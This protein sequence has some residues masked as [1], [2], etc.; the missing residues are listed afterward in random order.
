MG[1]S[2]NW[3]GAARLGAAV[4]LAAGSPAAGIAGSP[5]AGR[6]GKPLLEVRDLAIKFYTDD[7]VV[8]AV[9]G[10]SLSLGAGET[11]GLVGETGAGKTTT[12]L[13]IMGLVDSPPGRVE[14]GRILFEGVDLLSLREEQYRKYRGREISMIFQDPMTALNP[15][16]TVLDQI[17]E[18]I[19]NH[20]SLKPREAA[21][22]AVEML[23]LVRIPE[24]RAYDYPHQF[25][26]GMKQRVV[27]AIALACNPKLLIADEPTTALDVT[28]Q[29]QVLEIM[30]ELKGKLNTSM[31]MITHDLGVVSEI[32]D[33]VAIMYAGEIIE[34]GSLADIFNDP[35][36]PY[37]NGLFGSIPNIDEDA[38]MLSPIEGMMPDPTDLPSG[39][40]FH[41]RCK[42]A[43]GA[44]AE[45]APELLEQ[46]GDRHFVRCF[47]RGGGLFAKGQGKA[48][49][50]D[51]AKAPRPEQPGS[52]SKEAAI[53][54]AKEAAGDAAKAPRPD[55][56]GQPCQSAAAAGERAKTAAKAA[57]KGVAEYA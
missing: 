49:A 5:A 43:E 30:K 7:G 22:K 16:L 56:S 50:W 35:L 41:T 48:A 18:V 55:Q 47:M 24:E 46:K 38:D 29:A 8:N 36:H 44:C 53:E 45:R 27:I 28:I 40:K 25:S 31:V 42:Y 20:Q 6:A 10:V 39:C 37:T 9:N 1:K 51:A 21:Q 52:A 17:T 57:A 32:C 15:V 34:S 33:S 2:E 3:G 14:R 19:E 11:L 4:G 23:E 12:A 13:G 26:G 54:A